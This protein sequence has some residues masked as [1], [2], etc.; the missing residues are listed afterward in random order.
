MDYAIQRRILPPTESPKPV[1][2]LTAAS[3]KFIND[4]PYF[5]DLTDDTPRLVVDLTVDLPRDIIDLTDDLDENMKVETVIC[6]DVRFYLVSTRI[7]SLFEH[8]LQKK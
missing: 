5:V 2:D 1:I 3:P 8:N 4:H 7:F 6:V